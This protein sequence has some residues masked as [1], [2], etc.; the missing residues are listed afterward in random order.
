MQQ[1]IQ[2]TGR[3][4]FLS[5]ASQLMFNVCPSL[6]R[7]YMSEFQQA[8]IE[9]E[10]KPTKQMERSACQSCGEIAIPGLNT[11]VRVIQKNRKERKKKQLRAKNLIET[12]CLT[13]S[14][15]KL[16]HGSFKNKL[17]Q[18]KEEIGIVKQEPEVKKKK[19]KGKNNNLKALL[20]KQQQKEKKPNNNNSSLLGDFL[21]CL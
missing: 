9:Y 3:L 8:L 18:K 21:S 5:N 2:Q 6:S 19:N 13:C 12:T 20:A 4:D 16:Y 11:A 7:F 10:L 17:H 14:R 1:P 15:V